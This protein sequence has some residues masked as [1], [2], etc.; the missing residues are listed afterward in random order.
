[1]LVITRRRGEVFHIAGGISIKIV[2]VSGGKVRVGVE[3][4]H[5]VAVLRDELKLEIEE[6]GVG[7]RGLVRKGSV[8]NA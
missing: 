3:A 1:M 5:N 7:V 2:D 4:P 8:A 6:P